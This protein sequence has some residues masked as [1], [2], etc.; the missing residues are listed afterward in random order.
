MICQ[1]GGSSTDK[2]L[3]YHGR[4]S[5][6]ERL[7]KL[8]KERKLRQ[9]E[10][11]DA[12]NVSVQAVSGWERGE[13]RPKLANLIPVARLLNTTVD[14]LL[15]EES[16]HISSESVAATLDSAPRRRL[17]VKGY[18][19]AGSEAHF[20]NVNQG[21]L[22]TVPARPSD[23]PGAVAVEIMG[24]SLGDLFDRWYAIY[25]DVRSP[26]TD[27]LIGHVCVVELEDGRILIKKIERRG[28]EYI[29]KSNSSDE[30]PIRNA[31]IVWAAKVLD[32]RPK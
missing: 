4:M 22:D 11:A 26:V 2:A 13:E 31:K 30:K 20:Y 24:T 27:D 10:L 5:F 6:P 18:V 9:W 32:M 23:P 16:D 7:K 1:A 19:G 15:E 25:N 17:H 3:L 28:D 14:W 8:R 21:D 12:A 29:L